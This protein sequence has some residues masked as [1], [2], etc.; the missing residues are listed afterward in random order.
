MSDIRVELN[1]YSTGDTET[2]PG[3]VV[4]VSDGQVHVD[5]RAIDDGWPSLDPD[6]AR[7]LAAVLNHQ[8]REAEG[9]S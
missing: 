1:G 6:E 9:Q 3:I 7:A 5:A 2:A 8:A 4:G